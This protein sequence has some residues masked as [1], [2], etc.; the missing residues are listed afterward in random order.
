MKNDK[1][2]QLLPEVL[3]DP[4]RAHGQDGPRQRTLWRMQRLAAAAAAGATLGACSKSDGPTKPAHDPS[5]ATV[6]VTPPP[7]DAGDDSGPAPARVVTTPSATAPTATT[8]PT[9]P[10]GYAVVDP[11]PPPARCTGLA[12]SIKASAHWKGSNIQVE[13]GK[14]GMHGATYTTG[15]KP[16]VYTVPLKRHSITAHKVSLELG[17]PKGATS[18]GVTLAASCPHGPEHLRITVVG[19]GGKLKPGTALRV[20]LADGY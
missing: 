17:I 1:P 15:Q 13:L 9:R 10:K 7:P 5:V 2:K 14:P 12:Q 6:E 16:Q 8:A 20:V 3:P 18:I 19:S 4:T 11:M